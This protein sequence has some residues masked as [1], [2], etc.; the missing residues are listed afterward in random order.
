MSSRPTANVHPDGTLII[1]SGP[2]GAGK[3]SL[4]TRAREELRR[5]G[6][7]LHFSVSH[8]TREP[9]AGE[10]EGVEYY[11]VERPEFEA[12]VGRGEFLEWAHVHGHRY[13]TS[14]REVQARLERDE[15]VIVDIDVQG[16]RQI[17][18]NALLKPRSLSIFV[19]PPSF[20]ELDRRI[21][22]RGLNTEDQI[23]QRLRKASDEIGGRDIYD[24][25]IIND[26]FELAAEC[27]K[28]AILSKKLKSNA[29]LDAL[30]EMATRFKEEHSGR[31]APGSR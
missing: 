12:M 10:N 16:A 30:R 21:R 14:F 5:F 4:I 24:Y 15:D 3:T 25:V 20:E 22:R 26:D 19:F 28:A 9:R 2:S 7:D 1:V 6:I 23:E 11:F 8:T 17:A 29:A 18:D 27:L 13:G 31:T